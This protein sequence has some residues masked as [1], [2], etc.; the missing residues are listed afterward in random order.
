MPTR[1]EIET[2]FKKYFDCMQSKCK[3]ETKDLKTDYRSIR[4]NKY[5]IKGTTVPRDISEKIHDEQSV[6]K[7]GKLYAMCSIKKCENE[8]RTMLE[9]H[10]VHAREEYKKTKSAYYKKV[11]ERIQAIKLE[12]LPKTPPEKLFRAIY[13]D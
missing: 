6:A 2:P 12:D 5:K 10:L 13:I 11:I 9:H 4:N 1:E 8:L 3:P 7:V